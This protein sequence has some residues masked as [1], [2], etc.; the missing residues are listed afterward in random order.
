MKK[1]MTITLILSICLLMAGVANAHMLKLDD[2]WITFDGGHWDFQHG[3]RFL[4]MRIEFDD[5]GL[6]LLS[7]RISP[8]RG[9]SVFNDMHVV[10]NGKVLYKLSDRQKMDIELHTLETVKKAYGERLFLDPAVKGFDFDTGQIK[11][12]FTSGDKK[13][14]VTWDLNENSFAKE[15]I[16]G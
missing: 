13:Y 7:Y 1:T 12:Y 11:W 4:Q 8:L 9:K 16:V 2:Q 5:S 15:E 14:V 3:V 10:G 6:T